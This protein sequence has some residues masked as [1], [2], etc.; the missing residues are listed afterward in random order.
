MRPPR[1]DFGNPIGKH[2]A[3]A[4]LEFTTRPQFGKME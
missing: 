4:F 3:Q 1:R 2:L